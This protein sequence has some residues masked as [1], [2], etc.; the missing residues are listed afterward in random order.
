MCN[1]H[2]ATLKELATLNKGRWLHCSKRP[3]IEAM[4]LLPRMTLGV[5]QTYVAVTVPA[6]LSL[7][8]LQPGQVLQVPDMASLDGSEGPTVAGNSARGR[9]AEA[10][11][12]H[13]SAMGT[14][15]AN[16]LVAVKVSRSI[17]Q[18][19]Q[20][21]PS[22]RCT[23]CPVAP[24]SVLWTVVLLLGLYHSVSKKCNCNRSFADPVPRRS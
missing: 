8:A 7:D 24:C 16:G 22:E 23:F 12:L 9:Q 4:P 6:G 21:F 3:F 10:A 14:A 17:A 1:A 20:G 11:V 5:G 19:Q 15:P 13:A 18:L 2:G